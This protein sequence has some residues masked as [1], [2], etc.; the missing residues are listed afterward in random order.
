[1][2]HL[3]LSEAEELVV[4]R[5]FGMGEAANGSTYEGTVFDCDLSEVRDATD[6]FLATL[7]REIDPASI[8]ITPDR[9]D[10]MDVPCVA[11]VVKIGE[12]K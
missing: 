2:K 4:E 1:M 8:T 12:M 10:E 3:T 9:L 7:G 5:M 6:A 11:V